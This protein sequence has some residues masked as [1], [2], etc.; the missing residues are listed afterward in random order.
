VWATVEFLPDGHTIIV[1]TRDGA[2][3]TWDTR[4]EHWIDFAC[5]VTGR[6]LTGVEWRDAFGER[7]YRETCP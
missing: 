6:S 7:D 3:Y 1:G 5:R 4:V 2:V